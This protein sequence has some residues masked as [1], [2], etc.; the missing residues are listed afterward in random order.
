MD[1]SKLFPFQRDG[2][3]RGLELGGRILIGDEMGLGKTVQAIA[4]ATHYRDE[5]PL[6]V[7]CPTS[8]ALPWAEELERWYPFLRPGD[9]NLVRSHHNGALRFAKVTILS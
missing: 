2:V 6:L 3:A 1:E 9:I 7:L 8:M 5:W 4:L